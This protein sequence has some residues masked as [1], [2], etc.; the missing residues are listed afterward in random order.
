MAGIPNSLRGAV[1]LSGLGQGS[2]SQAGAQQ[3]SP[4]AAGHAAVPA[5]SPAGTDVV[6]TLPDVVIDGGQ[7]DLERLAPLS[8][9]VPVLVEMYSAATEAE[10]GQSPLASV[11][12]EAQG[13]LVLLRINM[14]DDPALGDR[15]QTIMLLGGRPAPLF[16]AVPP[17]EQVAQ[18]LSELLAAAQQQGMTGRVATDSSAA[19][20]APA[21]PALPPL[22]QEAQDALA[23]GDIDA[24]K[25]AYT[26]ALETNPGDDDAR[27]GIAQVS[28]LQ[29]L[30]GKTLAEIRERAAGAPDDLD[31]QL[32]VADL[33]LSGGHVVDAFERLLGL[34]AKAEADD[35]SRIRERLLDMFD[36]VG[37]QDPR[38]VRARQQLTNL[39]F[40]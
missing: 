9:Q 11:I 16:E 2:S 6:A 40:S 12:R 21:A 7:A 8:A 14:D 29:R 4:V 26:R 10:Q 37:A 27:I 32:D 31:A 38:V 18:V 19:D 15:P 25:S 39:L 28:L 23:A 17:R 5:G 33:D 22:H 24:A 20:E 30:R 34:F 1:D 3:D 36:I 13:R 35:K